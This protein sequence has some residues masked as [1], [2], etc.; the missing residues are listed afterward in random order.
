ML[1]L[2]DFHFLLAGPCTLRHYVVGFSYLSKVALLYTCRNFRFRRTP[3]SFCFRSRS[4][5]L[6]FI[7]LVV[8]EGICFA[9]CQY[10]PHNVQQSAL[11][12]FF[13]LYRTTSPGLY[14]SAWPRLHL[15]LRLWLFESYL[16]LP[17]LHGTQMYSVF[18]TFPSLFSNGDQQWLLLLSLVPV[19]FCHRFCH[20]DADDHHCDGR[21]LGL[22][23]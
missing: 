16:L 2:F 4:L 5:Q 6:F 23:A 7:G 11:V 3:Q 21:V 18:C 12:F 15:W 14:S 13:P 22:P 20:L 9:Y 19:T 10:Y 17:I 1:Q 8:E